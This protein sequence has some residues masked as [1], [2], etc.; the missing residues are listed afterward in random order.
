M[1]MGCS[2][3]CSWTRSRRRR[4]RSTRRGGGDKERE[5]EEEATQVQGTLFVF[6]SNLLVNKVILDTRGSLFRLFMKAF[7]G[8][9]IRHRQVHQ[10]AAEAATTGGFSVFSQ[11]FRSIS[12]LE[13]RMKLQKRKIL[14]EKALLCPP[15]LEY[16]CFA[17]WMA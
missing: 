8:S 16:P 10:S 1:R 4:L 7:A 3:R 11:V 2:I 13:S 6:F 15:E 9:R 12:C 5:K 17:W 14:S